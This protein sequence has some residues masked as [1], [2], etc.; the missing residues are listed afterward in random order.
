MGHVHHAERRGQSPGRA[1]EVIPHIGHGHN[2]IAGGQFFNGY[3]QDISGHK[4]IQRGPQ[5]VADFVE[6][7]AF[8]RDGRCGRGVG[9]ASPAGVGGLDI[10]GHALLCRFIVAQAVHQGMEFRY[11]VLVRTVGDA[12]VHGFPDFL[13]DPGD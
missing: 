13:I 11:R 2:G 1:D 8:V 4:L 10:V 5:P 9:N 3:G 7:P 6:S 12:G